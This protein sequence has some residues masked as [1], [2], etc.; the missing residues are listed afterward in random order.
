MAKT[1][2]IKTPDDIL[3]SAFKKAQ[4]LAAQK[5]SD[6]KKYPNP[7]KHLAELKVKAISDEIINSLRVPFKRMPNIEKL[8]PFYLHL[9]DLRVGKGNA[10]DAFVRVKSTL[11]IAMNL[12]KEYLGKIRE[13]DEYTEIAKYVTEFSGRISSVVKK[14]KGAM[15]TLTS[16]SYEVGSRD[17]LRFNIPSIVIAG[18]PN[19][20]KS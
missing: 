3:D 2:Q 6:A 1:P 15:E 7:R 19:V 18:Y 20:G 9:I 14:S 10:R 8:P 16:I 4:K 17:K 5:K 12:K 13:T 11:Q